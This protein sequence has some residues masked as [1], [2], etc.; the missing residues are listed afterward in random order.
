MKKK[1]KTAKY[2]ELN[3]WK[4]SMPFKFLCNIENWEDGLVKEMDFA[5]KSSALFWNPSPGYQIDRYNREHNTN[6][7]SW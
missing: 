3:K 4:E 5:E 2:V 1:K 6:R 7:R